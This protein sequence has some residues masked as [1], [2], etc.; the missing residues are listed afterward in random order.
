MKSLKVV[1]YKAVVAFNSVPS[2]TNVPVPVVI[3]DFRSL[4]STPA[5]GIDS[6]T[7]LN[8]KPDRTAEMELA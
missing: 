1:W 8:S 5:A 4:E 3:D 6:S 2:Q 7:P